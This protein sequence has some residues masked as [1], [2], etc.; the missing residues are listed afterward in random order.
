MEVDIRLS[1]VPEKLITSGFMMTCDPSKMEIL[2]ADVYDGSVL[3]GPWDSDMTNKVANPSGPGTYMVIVGNL[4][5][6]TP[7]ESSNINI[8]RLRVNC[9]GSCDGSFTVT[10]VPNFDTMVGNSSTIYD[11]KMPPS[12]FRLN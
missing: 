12:V 2:G 7:D 8:A 6:V 4:G 11:S 5:S 3:T 9:T 10:P 1:D